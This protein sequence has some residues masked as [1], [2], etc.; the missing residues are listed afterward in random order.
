MPTSRVPV[1]PLIHGHLDLFA[2]LES[3]QA[4]LRGWVFRADTP[5]ETVDISLSGKPWVSAFRLQERPDVRAA[6]EPTL[7]PTPHLTWSGFDLTAPLPPGLRA[8]SATIVSL[9]PHRS[10]GLSLD[11]LHTYFLDLPAALAHEP[12]PPPHLQERVGGSD[13]F[14]QVASQLTT[15]LLT[16]I[17]KH[18]PL[19]E[20]A[21]IL[22]WGCGCG[23]IVAQLRKLVVPE[24]LHG[25]DID[26]AAI[27]WDQEHLAG[28]HFTRIKPYP[29]TPY[30]DKSFDV[31]Y[32]ISVMTHLD[33]E[34]QL[35]WL[36]E[37]QRITRPGAI[38]ALSV[39]GHDL[40]GTNMPADLAPT[41]AEKGFAAFVPGYS[42][43]LAEFSHPGYY[44]EAYHSLD[45]IVS[46]W[47]RF[48]EILEYVETRHQDIVLLRAR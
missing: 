2:A 37:L 28:P 29:P 41:Y 1:T 4:R 23:R 26:A 31:V 10:D 38:L 21:E 3:G 13:N 24:K 17:G 36:K 6:Y 44:K 30:P 20:P 32:G 34:A 47:G 48:F 46:T 9:T 14:V 18:K 16:C 11:S 27:A 33:E 42:D 35:A 8:D 40:R 22:D 5:I 15:L 19:W 12:Q 45:Y 25:C 43:L 39:I 7:G